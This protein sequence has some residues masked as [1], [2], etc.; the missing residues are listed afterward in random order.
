M[1]NI[2]NLVLILTLSFTLSCANKR[3]VGDTPVS[4]SPSGNKGPEMPVTTPTPTASL[5]GKPQDAIASP[6]PGN[7]KSRVTLV[8]GGAGVASFATVGLLKR[9]QEEGIEIDSIV[10]TGWPTL[11]ALGYSFMKSVHDL[12]W[13]AMRLQEKDFYKAGIFEGAEKGYAAHDVL[14]KLIQNSFKQKEIGEGRIPVVISAGNTELSERDV[15]D[16]GDW[17]T[18]LLMTMSVPGIYRPYPQSQDHEAI[19]SL[20]GMDVSEA[21]KRGAKT[22]VAVNM[23]PDYFKHLKA[24]RKDTSDSVFRKLY[25]SQLKKSIAIETKDVP[26][27]GTISMDAPVNDFNVKRN[28]IFAGYKEGTRLARLI[29]SQA[30]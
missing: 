19:S 20:Q 14:S 15:F 29:R 24:E 28:A 8:L 4:V 3:P 6:L 7:P 23:Y 25:L 13:F 1:K 2:V 27:I 21:V 26:F 11:F 16:H 12:E 5:D 22:V 18:P 30:K 9:F 17:K 10:S